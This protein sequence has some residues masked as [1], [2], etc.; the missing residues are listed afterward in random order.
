MSLPE[1]GALKFS[2]P[3]LIFVFSII[4]LS[5]KIFDHGI[6]L[7]SPSESKCFFPFENIVYL[8]LWTRS[9]D[10]MAKAVFKILVFGMCFFIAIF[11][12]S[13]TFRFIWRNLESSRSLWE[14][15]C[16]M[17]HYSLAIWFCYLSGNLGVLLQCYDEL[18]YQ[19]HS[20]NQILHFVKIAK[21]KDRPIMNHQLKQIIL[22]R[23]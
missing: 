11:L 14:Q 9:F 10:K 2:T 19:N 4:S 6:H 13:T 12:F 18:L 22:G 8:D 20:F 17:Y 15:D 1:V 16:S 5:F 21:M 23:E 3:R 7:W